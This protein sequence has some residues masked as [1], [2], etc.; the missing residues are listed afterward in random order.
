MKINLKLALS[1]NKSKNSIEE[2]KESLAKQQQNMEKY[3]ESGWTLYLEKVVDVPISFSPYGL[4]VTL[5][6]PFLG[7]KL[8]AVSYNITTHLYESN[9]TLCTTPN[10]FLKEYKPN[11]PQIFKTPEDLV[12][13][14]E[15]LLGH[16]WRLCK[17]NRDDEPVFRYFL[18]DVT[19]YYERMYFGQEGVITNKVEKIHRF[20]KDWMSYDNVKDL[21]LERL[22]EARST[23]DLKEATKC[24]EICASKG[25]TKEQCI[26]H[27]EEEEYESRHK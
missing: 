23:F 14:G 13:V 10:L 16:G 17:A 6:D 11:Y 15:L 4:F 25:H 2:D 9:C 12:K 26:F 7:V 1:L 21:S 19:E 27:K 18:Q 20:M 24:C 22:E 5:E 3:W 8:A